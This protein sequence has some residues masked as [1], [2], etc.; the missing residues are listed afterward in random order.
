MRWQ[1][2]VVLTTV[3]W[4]ALIVAVSVIFFPA[5]ARAGYTA[6][7]LGA[8]GT[9]R[10]VRWLKKW[11]F[12]A[13]AAAACS[14]A[15]GTA[16]P[17]DADGGGGR[18]MRAPGSAV[19][20]AEGEDAAP[21]PPGPAPDV[22]MPPRPLDAMGAQPGPA[23]DAPPPPRP[24]DAALVDA[25]GS[26]PVCRQIGYRRQAGPACPSG[27]RSPEGFACWLC[28]DE[29]MRAAPQEC[30]LD[31]SE[32]SNYPPTCPRVLCVRSCSHCPVRGASCS[33]D[34]GAL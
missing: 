14:S 1:V 11:I 26:Y 20:G 29:Q 3:G 4:I 9:G 2:A 33:G 24:L 23:L 22:A 5:C 7:A 10:E 8:P 6:G 21:R 32:T 27:S 30:L 15:S 28:T 34:G 16:G 19:P 18:M 13:A 12:M 31:V 17:A 25:V